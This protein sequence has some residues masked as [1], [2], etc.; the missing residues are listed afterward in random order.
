MYYDWPRKLGKT[1][2][3]VPLNSEEHS[4]RRSPLLNGPKE[5]VLISWFDSKLNESK[6]GAGIAAHRNATR[7]ACAVE[8]IVKFRFVFKTKSVTLAD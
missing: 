1:T 4:N 5:N 8:A 6:S 3:S 2:T 7:S